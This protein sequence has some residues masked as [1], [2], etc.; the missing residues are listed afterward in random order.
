MQDDAML[1]EES[2][3]LL[4]EMDWLPCDLANEF[5]RRSSE[6]TGL[7]Q[8]VLKDLPGQLRHRLPFK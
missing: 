5:D 2:R 7:S 6:L 3:P 4:G 8:G 1:P